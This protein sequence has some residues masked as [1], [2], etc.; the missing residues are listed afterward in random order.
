M[1]SFAV[2]VLLCFSTSV[3]A[4]ISAWVPVEID[5]GRVLMDITLNGKP[6]KAML[7]TGATH[8]GVS[9]A[10]LENNEG[11]YTRGKWIELQGIKEDYETN[12][13][14]GLKVGM[15]GT[16]IDLNNLWPMTVEG[17]DLIIGVPFFEQFVVQIDYPGQRIRIADH[18]T[19]DLRK[20]SN[21]EMKWSTSSLSPM[22][23]V[24]LNGEKDAWLDLD[25][26]NTGGVF[27]LRNHAEDLGW[28]ERYPSVGG[29]IVGISGEEARTDSFKVPALTLGPF[30][31]ENVTVT[32]PAEGEHLYLSTS[33]SVEDSTRSRIKKGRKS[34]GQLGYD[35]LRHFI[36]SIDY[37]RE[38]VNLDIPR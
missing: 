14:N 35:L 24:D 8:N 25:T 26:G 4:S 22:L 7:D 12:E 1:R 38:L 21:V 3:S 5:N 2:F 31:M 28:L 11:E 29:T 33:R 23:R 37:K 19:L 17:A 27:M 13:I 6:A 9:Q 34:E 16:E 20:F 36:V 10:Y 32:V 15:F 30:E 18:K